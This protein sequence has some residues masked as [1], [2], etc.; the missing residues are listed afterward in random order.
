MVHFRA[1][2][3]DCDRVE[4]RTFLNKMCS[5]SIKDEWRGTKIQM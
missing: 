5:N 1:G 3:N 4:W 2:K